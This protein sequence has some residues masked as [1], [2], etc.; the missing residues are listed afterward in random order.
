MY[1]AMTDS[2]EVIVEPEFSPDRS[3][4]DLG[5]FF[6]IYAVE[7]RNRGETTVQLRAR[8][9]EITDATGKVQHVRGLGVV[10]EQPILKPGESFRYSSGCPLATASGFMVGRYEMVAADGRRF[11]VAVPAFSLDTPFDRRALN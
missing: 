10:G 2:I 8:H 4:P 6:W 11:E 9:W 7:I 5:E 1:R 3:R